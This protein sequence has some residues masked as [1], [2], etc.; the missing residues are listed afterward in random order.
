MLN[1]S[2]SSLQDYTECHRRFQLMHIE[3]LAWPAVIA[4]PIQRFEA[5]TQRGAEFH[6]RVHQ[7]HLGIPAEAIAPHIH[8][9]DVKT[10]WAAYLQSEYAH[11]EMAGQRYP[12]ITLY[13]HVSG[14]RIVA[15]LDLLIV[16]PERVLIID[17]KTAE[18]PPSRDHLLTRWQTKLYPYVVVQAG[19]ELF[20][21]AILPEQVQMVYWFPNAPKHPVRFDYSQDQYAA[22]DAELSALLP[23]I[24]EQSTFDKTPNQRL[25]TYCVY[26]SLCERGIRAGEMDALPDAED[27][28]ALTD[29]FSLDIPLD[30]V[31]EVSF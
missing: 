5:H 24:A 22:T 15:K 28:S 17:W 18:R 2:Q 3:N 25:C 27:V 13:A 7:H 21:E 12:E 6:H 23:Q 30:D 9:E 11:G 14:Q 16:T 19:A 8:D 10:W 4:E 26:R 29:D 1:F 20:E 31:G